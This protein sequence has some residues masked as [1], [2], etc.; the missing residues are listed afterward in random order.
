MESPDQPQDVSIIQ[1]VTNPEKHHGKVIRVIGFLHLGFEA[2]GLYLHRED[3]T[4]ALTHNGVWVDTTGV[5]TQ[6]QINDRY[7]RLTGTFDAKN[8]GHL[9]MWSG[10]IK[11]ITQT[12]PWTWNHEEEME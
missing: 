3:F 8:R 5:A 4:Q 6:P 1:L 2:N 12:L 10:S 11:N 9:G 7:A